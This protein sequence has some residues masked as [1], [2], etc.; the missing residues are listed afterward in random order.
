MCTAPEVA[1][2]MD[3]QARRALLALQ[4]R[5]SQ[6]WDSGM[7]MPVQNNVYLKPAL[8][9]ASLADKAFHGHLSWRKDLF[10]L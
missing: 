3:L 5:D 2:D 7:H 9:S 1:D 10:N 6:I 8:L 4:G